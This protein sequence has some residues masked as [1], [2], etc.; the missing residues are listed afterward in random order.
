MAE[1]SL[2]V[3]RRDVVRTPAE[4][5]FG[6]PDPRLA[7]HVLT[8]AAHDY[9]RMDLTPWRVAPLGVVVVSVE[10]EAPPVRRATAP[11]PEAGRDVPTSPVLGLR[12]RPWTVEQAGPSRGITIA[13]TPAG[14]Y[15]LFGLPLRELANTAVGLDDLLGAG[16]H[17]LAERIAGAPDWTARFRLLDDYLA[18]RVRHGPVLARQVHGAW[19]RLTETAGRLRVEALADEVGWTRQHLG[20]RFREQIGLTPKTFAR[21]AR[22]HHAASLLTAASPPAWADVARTCGYAD[23]A[24]LNRDFRTLTGCTPTEFLTDTASRATR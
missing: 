1:W 3:P 15:A 9:R 14:A 19:H 10:L 18:A 6:R 20:T 2:V 4:R 24:H 16:A 13:M 17:L 5:V 22:L 12:D 11:D 8:Y 7:G 23:Q 21:V